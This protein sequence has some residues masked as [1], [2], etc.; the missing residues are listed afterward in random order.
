MQKYYVIHFTEKTRG[1]PSYSLEATQAVKE[2]LS[3]ILVAI[4]DLTYNGTMWDP[5]TG[6]G[7]CDW[8]SPT[9]EAV[10]NAMNAL[11]IPYDAIVPVEPLKL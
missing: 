6:I 4:P 3:D 11:K 2:A 9:R 8:D 1:I 7:I 5:T 10:E